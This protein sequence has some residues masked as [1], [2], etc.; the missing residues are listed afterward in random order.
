[1]WVFPK[2]G[3]GPP[4]HPLKNRV[5]HYFH[6]PFWGPTL[7]LGWHP[8]IGKPEWCL[9]IVGIHSTPRKKRT[10]DW[11]ENHLIFNRRYIFRMLVDNGKSPFLIG[12]TSSDGWFSPCHVSFLGCI[13][14]MVFPGLRCLGTRCLRCPWCC[15]KGSA[16][17]SQRVAGAG[18]T[19]VVKLDQKRRSL[20]DHLGY[21]REIWEIY[22][23]KTSHLG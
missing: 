12:D 15:G 13:F 17:A 14:W 20:K 4:N 3:V 10:H 18:K 5:F 9:N 23:T 6:H 21:I 2:I 19:I 8:C 7:F 22:R 1:M 16:Q 11:L